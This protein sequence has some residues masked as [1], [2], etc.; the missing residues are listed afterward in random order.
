MAQRLPIRLSEGNQVPPLVP[1]LAPLGM[2]PP[3]ELA[4]VRLLAAF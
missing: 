1:V 3:L 4:A 2:E